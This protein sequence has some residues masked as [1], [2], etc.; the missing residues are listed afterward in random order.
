M[1]KDL[2]L[3]YRTPSDLCR[4]EILSKL[5]AGRLNSDRSLIFTDIY[6]NSLYIHNNHV[7]IFKYVNSEQYYSIKRTIYFHNDEYIIGIKSNYENKMLKFEPAKFSYEPKLTGKYCG[8]V[9]ELPELGN[10]ILLTETFDIS[11]H[12]DDYFDPPLVR[13]YKY[14][15]IDSFVIY[16][17]STI[18]LPVYNGLGI[19]ENMSV[20]HNSIEGECVFDLENG[21]QIYTLR[22]ETNNIVVMNN[23]GEILPHTKLKLIDK[24][25]GDGN[26]VYENDYIKLLIGYDAPSLQFINKIAGAKTK[27]AAHFD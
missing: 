23:L 12:S 13:D 20:L 3:S 4:C 17:D 11:G 2:N 25:D 22:D 10:F 18:S 9:Y 21:Q 24:Y 5:V 7:I 6:T 1:C 14:K 16:L 19:Y 26:C 15:D 27:A 8:H